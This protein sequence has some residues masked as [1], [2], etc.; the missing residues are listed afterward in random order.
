MSLRK[1]KKSLDKKLLDLEMASPAP[2]VQNETNNISTQGQGPQS[3]V[4]AILL[5]VGTFFLVP[6]HDIPLF[7]KILLVSALAIQLFRLLRHTRIPLLRKI[8]F[9]STLAS[10]GGVIL[11][12]FILV[13]FSI[14]LIE[15]P[16]FS[17][18]G[19]SKSPL[20]SSRPMGGI[21]DRF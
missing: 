10:N 20:A 17:W 3:L 12:L 5:L 11:F 2:L 14:V 16:S 15:F 4:F 8:G 1:K 13:C 6:R 21:G 9:N 18:M 7:G 19:P